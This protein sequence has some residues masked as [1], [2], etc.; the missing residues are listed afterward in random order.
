[1][2]FETLS[3]ILVVL[4]GIIDTVLILVLVYNDYEATVAAEDVEDAA[5]DTEDDETRNLVQ[6]LTLTYRAPRCWWNR[7]VGRR[8][9]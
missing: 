9:G 6:P 1:M 3:T 2:A 5:E 8:R 4:F 7:R